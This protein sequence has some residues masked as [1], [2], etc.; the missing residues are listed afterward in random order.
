MFQ[1]L[2]G[3][4]SKTL[5]FLNPQKYGMNPY[6]IPAFQAALYRQLKEE[7]IRETFRK[8]ETIERGND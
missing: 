5:K 7:T 8:E 6:D 1:T 4:G 3:K 2:G